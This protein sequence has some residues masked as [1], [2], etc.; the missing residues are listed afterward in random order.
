MNWALQRLRLLFEVV[1]SPEV[2]FSRELTGPSCLVPLCVF[3]LLS[4]V[5]S[6]IQFPLQ[7]EWMRFQLESADASAVQAAASLELVRRSGA[8]SV[9][10]APTLLFLRWLLLASIIWLVAGLFALVLDYSKTLTI[11]AY[12]YLPMVVRDAV[13]L[14]VLLLRGDQALYQPEG[15]NVAIGANL[16]LPW[17]QLPWSALAANINIF[18]VW[19]VSL[20]VIGISRAAKCRCT[21]A[22]AIVLP[23]WGIAV[24]AQLAFVVLGLAVKRSL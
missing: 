18:E 15:L 9:A 24:L 17:L 1:H 4:A 7:A 21:R 23:T 16:L 10:L 3:G 13:I 8:L 14:L 20:L 22:L 2:A 12:S 6:A 5:I 19:L 11:V